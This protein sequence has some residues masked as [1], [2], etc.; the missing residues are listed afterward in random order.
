MPYP[1]PE[2]LSGLRLLLF[3]DHRYKWHHFPRKGDWLHHRQLDRQTAMGKAPVG[4]AKL[5]KAHGAK[6]LAFSGS[7]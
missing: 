1:D 7:V 6:V 5:A 4:V 2:I 3:A